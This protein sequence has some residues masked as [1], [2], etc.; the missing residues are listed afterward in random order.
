MDDSALQRSSNSVSDV[1]RRLGGG[2][3]GIWRFN[4]DSI[5]GDIHQSDFYPGVNMK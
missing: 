4:E 1:P 2:R 3:Y 5:F